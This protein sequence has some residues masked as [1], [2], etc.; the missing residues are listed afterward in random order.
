MPAATSHR[1]V[2]GLP[3]GEAIDLAGG[4][5]AAGAVVTDEQLEGG[6]AKV[7]AAVA[8]EVELG[9]VTGGEDDALAGAEALPG[10]L[11][12]VR[13]GVGRDGRFL[14]AMHRGQPVAYPHDA[15]HEERFLRVALSS[16]VGS[17]TGARSSSDTSP[18]MGFTFSMVAPRG[19]TRTLLVRLR[20]KH[21]PAETATSATR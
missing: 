15:D 9:A 18:C 11:Q 8:D 20:T 1:W 10:A 7:A 19:W 5:G 4:D 13:Q 6:G 21:T 2:V 16:G 17:A 14:S 12:H 3:A